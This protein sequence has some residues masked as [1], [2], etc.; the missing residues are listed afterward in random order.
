MVMTRTDLEG[1][2][3]RRGVLLVTPTS[4]LLHIRN[5]R[6]VTG[7]SSSPPL[8]VCVKDDGLSGEFN[9][10]CRRYPVSHVP[11]SLTGPLKVIISIET[12]FPL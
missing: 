2:T 9:L 7:S 3:S 10:V 6:R 4:F 12:Y 8:Y 1:W 5:V 11:P